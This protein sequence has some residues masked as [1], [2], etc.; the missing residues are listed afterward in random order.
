MN[1]LNNMVMTK[2]RTE[3]S[4]WGQVNLLFQTKV[5]CDY[6]FLNEI[7]QYRDPSCLGL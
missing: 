6:T 3:I 4:F 2:K 1:S 7:H 5:L